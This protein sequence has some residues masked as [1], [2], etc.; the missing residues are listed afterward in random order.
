MSGR[1]AGGLTRDCS[2]ASVKGAWR[3]E[4]RRCEGVAVNGPSWRRPGP[5][6]FTGW[7]VWS[8]MLADR[9]QLV[10][11]GIPRAFWAGAGRAIQDVLAPQGTPSK[12][13]VLLGP[14]PHGDLILWHCLLHPTLFPPGVPFCTPG[15]P[16]T[17]GLGSPY[18]VTDYLL[19][20]TSKQPTSFRLHKCSIS[21]N[22][23]QP[24]GN[25]C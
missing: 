2:G 17:P 11:M 13:P 3:A 21:R 10:E 6:G 4:G 15:T 25:C 5:T 1:E 8:G 23:P 18:T 22:T 12:Y 19:L 16:F 14:L 24:R 20:G 9:W 7:G